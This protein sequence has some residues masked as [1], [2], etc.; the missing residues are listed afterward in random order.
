MRNENQRLANPVNAMLN[1]RYACLAAEWRVAALTPRTRSQCRDLPRDIRSQDSLALD[2]MGPARSDVDGFV[3]NLIQ[4]HTNGR[5]HGQGAVG[6]I[7]LRR[8][9]DLI[10]GRCTR[11]LHQCQSVPLRRG[12]NR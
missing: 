9:V 11:Y 1:Y 7:S 5:T 6:H 2:P 8:K 12:E 4:Q 3:L 10:C